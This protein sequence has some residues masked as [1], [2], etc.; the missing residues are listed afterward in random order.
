MTSLRVIQ[1][2]PQ[3]WWKDEG[4]KTNRIPVL[5]RLVNSD[6][7]IVRNS[8]PIRLKIS[9]FYENKLETPISKQNIL[10]SNNFSLVDGECKIQFRIEEVS[11]SHFRQNFVIKI[12]AI[13][14]AGVTSTNISPIFTSP[15][16]VKSK[17]R[18]D[19]IELPEESDDSFT[20]TNEPSSPDLPYPPRKI[21]RYIRRIEGIKNTLQKEK[22][23]NSK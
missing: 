16:E 10:S 8:E 22:Y 17:R 5:V 6:Q 4:G 3:K 15:I 7:I 1:H 14:S 18:H 11:R 12:E 21:C 20:P 19:N 23:P 9:L 2:P 13:N